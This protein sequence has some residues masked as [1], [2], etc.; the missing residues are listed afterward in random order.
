MMGYDR[1]GMAQQA[2][3]CIDDALDEGVAQSMALPTPWNGNE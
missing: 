1:G 3:Y 2:N